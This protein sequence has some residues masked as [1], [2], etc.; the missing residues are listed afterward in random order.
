MAALF[1]GLLDDHRTCFLADDLIHESF[2]DGHVSGGFEFNISDPIV[3]GL[4]QHF[5]GAGGLGR[6]DR[7][8]GLVCDDGSLLIAGRLLN[9]RLLNRTC[10]FF[11]HESSS[12]FSPLGVCFPV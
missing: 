2:W 8:C 9:G 3:H 7:G 1:S 4:V 11:G 5:V 6:P 12:H 10:V